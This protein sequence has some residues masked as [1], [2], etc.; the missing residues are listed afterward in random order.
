MV[1]V[2]S[3]A[4]IATSLFIPLEEMEANSANKFF[5]ALAAG[6][7]I[8]INYGGWQAELLHNNDAGIQIDR[9]ISVAADQVRTYISDPENLIVSGLNSRNLGELNFSRDD[10]AKELENVLKKAVY[11]TGHTL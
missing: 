8:L 6:C 3:A 1:N 2:L 11:E 7:P 4:D 5:D 9:N 10:L